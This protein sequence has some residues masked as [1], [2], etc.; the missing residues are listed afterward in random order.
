MSLARQLLLLQLVVVVV[1]VVVAGIAAVRAADDRATEQQRQR[2]LSVAE[3]LSVSGEVRAA[4]RRDD[5]SHVLQPLAERVRRTSDLGFVVFMSPAGV[6]FSPH[7][8]MCSFWRKCSSA[9]VSTTPPE[10]ALT[11]IPRGAS[12]TAR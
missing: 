7:S 8:S 4:L 5:P 9:S 6:R 3:S 2:A 1:A 10:T 12:S 11:R